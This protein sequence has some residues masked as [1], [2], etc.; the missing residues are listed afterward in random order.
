M[1][2]KN[3]LDHFEHERKALQLCLGKLDSRQKQ[4]T[5]SA[6]SGEK[7]IKEVAQLYGRTATALYKALKRI[8]T[9]LMKC[10]KKEVSIYE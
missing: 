7:N 2:R 8:R 10:I 9:N 3:N 5:M 6:Y 4:I 1:N